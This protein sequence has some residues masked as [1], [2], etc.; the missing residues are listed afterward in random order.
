MNSNR[1]VLSSVILNIVLLA[2]IFVLRDDRSSLQPKNNNNENQELAIVDDNDRQRRRRRLSL[3]DPKTLMQ[4]PNFGSTTPIPDE[5]EEEVMKMSRAQMQ[6]DQLLYNNFFRGKKNGVYLDVGANNAEFISNTFMFEKA[7]SWTGICF[8]PN[9]EFHEEWAKNRSCHLIKKMVSGIDM[10]EHD[11]YITLP[12]VLDANAMTHIDFISLDVEGKEIEILEHFD[13]EKYDV[14]VW[15]IE[16]FWLDDRIVDHIMLTNGYFKAA[17]LAIDA[18]YVKV[19]TLWF[20]PRE[21]NDYWPDHQKWRCHPDTKALI[22][23]KTASFCLH[24]T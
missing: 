3:P 16:T 12:E 17:Q 15:L 1:F 18:V 9:T 7:L 13:F 20:P 22:K 14:S 19:G 10:K 4:K 5:L 8:E 23:S 11:D 21:L 24:H 2:Y 6:Q